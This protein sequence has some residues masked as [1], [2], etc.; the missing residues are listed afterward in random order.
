MKV[1]ITG[2]SGLIGSA[3]SERLVRAG[4][5]VTPVSRRGGRGVVKWD[6]ERGEIDA[7][8]LEGHDVV[9]HLAGENVGGIWT[10]GKKRRI[11]ES[12]VK[13]TRLLAKTLASLERKPGVLVS[14]SASGFYGDRAEPVDELSPRGEGFLAG[15]TEAWERETRTAADA[16]IRVVCTRFGTVLSGRGGALSLLAPLFRLGLGGRLGSG[17]Q[18]MSWV[19]LDDVCGAVIHVLGADLAGPV[20]VVAPGVVTNAEFTRDL[21]SALHRPAWFPVPELAL[22]ALPGGMGKEMLLWG[23]RVVPRKLMESGFVFA[24]PALPD[25]LA[26]VLEGGHS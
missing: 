1:A 9:I 19:A 11:L 4:N 6:P 5:S 18:P 23:A 24:Y 21:A 10:R 2:A 22:R 3:L 13:G 20:N 25:A 16:G 7:E 15:V 17:R 12:R 14:S 8:R 26:H